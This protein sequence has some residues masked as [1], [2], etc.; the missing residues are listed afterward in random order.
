MLP[1]ED[2]IWVGEEMT[3]RFGLPLAVRA[4][5]DRRQPVHH[6]A[7]A[8]PHRPPKVLVHNW[9]YHG[10]V[11]ETFAVL[12]RRRHRVAAADNIGAAVDPT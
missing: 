8:P 7:R 12:D 3:R 1:T 6:P 9:C 4:H 5:R 2:A 11:D 10:T